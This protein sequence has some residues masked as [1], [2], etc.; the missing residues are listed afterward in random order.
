ME[1]AAASIAVADDAISHAGTN[2]DF[3]FGGT[4]VPDSQRRIIDKLELLLVGQLPTSSV[5]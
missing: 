2:P 4:D 3:L 1:P 5:N